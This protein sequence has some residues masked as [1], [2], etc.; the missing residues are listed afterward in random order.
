MIA[1]L[2]ALRAKALREL[3]AAQ[4]GEALERW[5]VQ[6]LGKKGAVSQSLRGLGNL[7]DKERPRAGQLA[8]EA[9]NVLETQY[10]ARLE[11]LA[12]AERARLAERERV[13]VSLP[14]H[15][16]LLG[17]VHPVTRIL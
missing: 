3:A 15:R 2:E 16:P 6:Y 7:P 9:R 1:Q 4:D 5:R 11:A 10:A 12:E 8:N 14:G 17:Q 13:D